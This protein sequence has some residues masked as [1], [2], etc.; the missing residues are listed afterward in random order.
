LA[1]DALA[2]RA[3]QEFT[4]RRTERAGDQSFWGIGVPS[5]FAN[6]SEQPA[7]ETNASAAVFGGGLRRGA[8]TGWWWHTPHDTEDKIDPD[9]LV[10]DTRVYQ[11]AVWRLLA[12]PVPPLDYAEAARELTT[13]LEAL[14]Q[15]DGR[16][17]DLS[18]CLRR[19]AEL[20]HRMARMRDTHG[21]DPVR[22]SECLRRLSRVLVPVTY[23]RGDRFGH[24]PALAQPA[25]P[26]LA[27]AS[28]L[29]LLPPGSDDHRFL[30]SR[31]VR[32]AN[33]IA[34]AL[35]EAIDIVD[36]YLDG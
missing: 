7:G 4:G 27:G 34:W 19:A 23:T 26:A 10:R 33:R 35:R 29:A 30:A 25:L 2:A 36:R 13:R 16:G 3:G 17:L 20:E 11:H 14:Q 22:T 6:M 31:L 12:S 28:R 8:G 5:I 21:A 9:I 15:G 24:D 32:E 1:R 18:L